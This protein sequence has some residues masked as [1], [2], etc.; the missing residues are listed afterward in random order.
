MLNFKAGQTATLASSYSDAAKYLKVA[1]ALRE[2][3]EGG[4]WEGERRQTTMM[5]YLETITAYYWNFEVSGEMRQAFHS[6]SG[7]NSVLC[8]NPFSHCCAYN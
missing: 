2:S 6:L 5:I 8:T 1:L 4:A 3:M 7:D